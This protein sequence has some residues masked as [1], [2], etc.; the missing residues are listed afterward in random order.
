[1]AR[2]PG[3]H[4]PRRWTSACW[5]CAASHFGH[6]P[7]AIL[8]AAR[9]ARAAAWRVKLRQVVKVPSAVKVPSVVEVPS[10]VMAPAARVQAT[11]VK[12]DDLSPGP[13]AKRTLEARLGK[14]LPP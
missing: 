9:A 11:P 6:V 4:D 12:E 5:C 7:A 14:R 8:R 1:M 10:V 13:R 3:R 2:E